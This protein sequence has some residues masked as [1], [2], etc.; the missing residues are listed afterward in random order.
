MRVLRSAVVTLGIAAPLLLTAGTAAAGTTWPTRPAPV[1]APSTGTA[2]GVPVGANFHGMW[3]VYSDAQRATILDGLKAAGVDSVRL[4]VSWAMLQP[5]GPATYDA[6]GTSFVDRVIAMANARGIKP[7]VMLWMTPGWANGN[8]GDRAL[9]T[10]PADYARVAQW[11]AARWNG[12]VVGWEVWNEPN[13][14]S[15]MVGADPVAYTRLL[16]A[17]YP[18][19]KAG[20]PTTPVITGGVEYNDTNWLTRMYAAGAKGSFDAIATHPYMGMADAD[21]GLRDDGTMWTFTHAAAVHQLMVANGDGAKKLWFT[22]YGWSTH[23]TAAGSPNWN[24]GVTEAT[25]SAY[26]VKAATIVDSTMPYVARMYLYSERDTSTGN[27]QY[28]SYGIYRTDFSA[29]PVLTGIRNAN[30]T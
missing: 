14:Q 16:K 15:F 23:A 17:A 26:V 11:S 20:S 24:R 29:K 4:D 25:Q 10:N 7:L 30:S 2:T 1:P 6:W 12:K 27:L 3:S 28:D 8:A 18:A 19:F 21:P 5:T 22:E 13:S 9:P